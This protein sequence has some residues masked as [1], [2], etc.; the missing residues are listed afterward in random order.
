MEAASVARSEALGDAAVSL[1]VPS[2]SVSDQLPC[3]TVPSISTDPSSRWTALCGTA[4]SGSELFAP[5]PVIHLI[6]GE[7]KD[8]SCRQCFDIKTA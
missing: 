3:A 2:A 6:Q 8:V 4:V 5:S 7:T 1:T